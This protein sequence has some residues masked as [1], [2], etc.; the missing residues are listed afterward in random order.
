MAVY[1]FNWDEAM[2]LAAA[3]GVCAKVEMVK[4]AGCRGDKVVIETSSDM[5][6]AE[7]EAVAAALLA[8]TMDLTKES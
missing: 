3:Q 1:G 4:L 7:T 8:V 2:L 5:D 6:A